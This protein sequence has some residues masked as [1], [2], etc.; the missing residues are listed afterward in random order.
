MLHPRIV[1]FLLC[2]LLLSFSSKAQNYCDPADCLFW[3][4]QP[5]A[6]DSALVTYATSQWSIDEWN[7]ISCSIPVP[8]CEDLDLMVYYPVLNPG[9]KRPLVV[10][11]HGGGFIEGNLNAFRIQARSF[12]RLGYVAATINYRLCKRNNCLLL[13]GLGG[14]PPALCGLNF[15]S[16]FGTGAYVATVDANNAIR[17]LQQHATDYSIDPDYVIVGGHSAGAWTA[18]HTAYLDQDEIDSL[19]N[20]QASWGPLNP[21]SGIRGVIGLSG[22]LVDTAFIDADEDIPAFIV[23]GL[24]DPTVCYDE[25]APFHC[26]A[27]YPKI[28]GGGLIGLRK[29]HLG[30]GYYLFSGEDM[31]HDVQALGSVWEIDLLRYM[32]ESMICNT[33]T[34]RHVVY[35]QIPASGECG[36]LQGSLIQAPHAPRDPVAIPT[37][38][39]WGDFPAPCGSASALDEGMGG[40]EYFLKAFPSPV[41]DGLLN[42]DSRGMERI[43]IYSAS[44]REL[45]DR[46]IKDGLTGIDVSLFPAGIL[47]VVGFGKNGVVRM[48]KVAVW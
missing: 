20:W 13:S 28:M 21:V 30:H 17:F 48:Q 22:A 42:L 3:S 14:F 29:H 9:E 34:Q 11:I 46:P 24:C 18:F 40:N 37:Q 33:F 2:G 23:H 7:N 36:I 6:I 4:P 27:S 5:E 15:W 25:D 10:L 35:S 31:G 16:D 43:Q 26:N 12:A 32:R 19:G 1:F 8:Q 38:S 41:L 47:I 39:V 45:A 44:G